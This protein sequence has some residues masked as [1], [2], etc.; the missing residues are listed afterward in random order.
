MFTVHWVG[1]VVNKQIVI[2]QFLAYV[3]HMRELAMEYRRPKFSREF[4]NPQQRIR[5]ALVTRRG[6]ELTPDYDDLHTRKG[7]TFTGELTPD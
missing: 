6:G 3:R 2:I 7:D 5:G 1:P 4:V